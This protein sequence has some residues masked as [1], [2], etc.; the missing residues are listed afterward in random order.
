MTK[1]KTI[2]SLDDPVMQKAIALAEV[3]SRHCK[4]NSLSETL[5]IAGVAHNLIAVM[6]HY[7]NNGLYLVIWS[8][9]HTDITA[10]PYTSLEKAIKEARSTAKNLNKYP[11]DYFE[12]IKNE[13]GNPDWFNKS[14]WEFHVNYSCEGDN[15]RVEKAE[16][17]KILIKAE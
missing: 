13:E 2:I 5:I 3:F 8:D 4:E 14:N 16:T 7:F 11:E 17:N 1:G 9:R 12:Y 15:L 6:R 10:H